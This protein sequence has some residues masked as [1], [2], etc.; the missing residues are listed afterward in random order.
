MSITIKTEYNT[1][2]A[3]M[4]AE[5]SE[6]LF[7]EILLGIMGT[8]RENKRE[9]HLVKDG[10]ELEQPE[11]LTEPEGLTQ[12]DPMMEPE[13]IHKSYRG[14]LYIKC[15]HCGEER[16]FCAKQPVSEY[17]CRTCGKVTPFE[18]LADLNVD[19]ECGKHFYYHTN[20][21]EYAFDVDCIECGT[22]VAVKWNK[23]KKMYVTI[24]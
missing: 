24:V 16:G 6:E 3:K 1:Y 8:D 15:Q 18:E 13:P 4:P 7:R 12:P 11:V 19:C 2:T 9:E 23:K 20:M 14:F 5:E 10:E 22:P 21:T 17:K